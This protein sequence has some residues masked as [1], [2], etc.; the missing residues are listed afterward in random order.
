[1]MRWC[2]E[3]VGFGGEPDRDDGADA[4]A[5]MDGQRVVTVELEV[6]D[7]FDQEADGWATTH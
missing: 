5:Y 3:G 6:V 4:A 1:M 7:D 2:G